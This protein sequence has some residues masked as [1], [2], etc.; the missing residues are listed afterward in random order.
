V[1]FVRKPAVSRPGLPPTQLLNL[2]TARVFEE[3]RRKYARG[4]SRRC[5]AEVSRSRT[6]DSKPI[7]SGCAELG[8]DYAPRSRIPRSRLRRRLFFSTS[9]KLLG[10]EN[11]RPSIWM[12]CRCFASLF[13]LLQIPRTICADRSV[14]NRYQNSTV[15][16]TSSRPI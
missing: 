14:S 15:S 16:S 4:R 13:E 2:S 11:F 5:A 12:N 10:H 3:I 7:C 9:N 1:R 8:L 6:L